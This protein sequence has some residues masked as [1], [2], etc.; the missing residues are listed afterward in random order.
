MPSGIS[1]SQFLGNN[2]LLTHRKILPKQESIT[3]YAVIFDAGSTGSRVHVYHFDQ[4]LDLLHIGTDLEFN[5][6]IKP[7]LSAYADDPEG[8]AESLIPLLEEAQSVVPE[9]MHPKTPLKLGATAGLRLLD[10][11]AS[12]EILQAVRDMFNNRSTLNVQSVDIIDG[13]EEGSYMWVTVNYLLGK[14]GKRFQKTVGVVD[15]GGGS[16]QMAYA[17]SRNTAKNAPI[18]PDGEDPYIKKLVL[19]GKKYDLY[20][21]SYLRYGREA[22]RVQ[23]LNVTAGSASPCLLAGFKGTYT[24]A[25]EEYKAIGPT[26]SSSFDECRETVLK[27][28]KV[29]APCPHKNCTFG[30]I[31]NG[32]GGSGQR[33]LFLA[34]SFYYL[35]AD[36]GIIDPNKPNSDIL[37]EDLKTEAKRACQTKFEDANS[38]YPLLAESR[39][40]YVCMD[41]TY[42]YTLLVDGFGLDPFQVV[43]VGKEIE[44]QDSVVDAAWPLGTAIEAISALPKFNRLMYFI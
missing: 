37:I 5:N 12:E 8:A 27:A 6:K 33:N 34:S 17:V 20:V 42:S 31:W 9:D 28:L 3:S 18:A 44:Y 29:N 21:H 23:I 25:G 39:L 38:T 7:G 19:K 11:D 36:V 14:L 32:G 2:I 16:V 41:L 26:F 24:Y 35:P 4:N 10:G 43:T 1:S 22:S 40:P 30:G 15:L 13:T